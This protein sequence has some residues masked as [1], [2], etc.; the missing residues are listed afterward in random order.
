MVPYLV[1]E[2]KVIAANDRF[3]EAEQ[4]LLDHTAAINQ[5]LEFISEIARLHQ[6]QSEE[7]LVALRLAIRCFNSGAAAL[8]LIRC[9]Y[10]QQGFS[11]VRDI[12]E[13]AFLLDLFEYDSDAFK[14]WISA[15]PRDREREFKTVKVRERLD[16]RDGFQDKKRA[17]AYQLFSKYASHPTPEGFA[18]ISP[19]NQTQIGP[20]PDEER[21]GAGLV[22]L[23]R[24]LSYA[25]IIISKHIPN[26]AG[27]ILELKTRHLDKIDAWYE[28]YWQQ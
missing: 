4:A 22:E 15:A 21:L 16:E 7:E 23:S 27:P 13:T 19:E 3:I 25:S 2:S 24:Y 20:F 6:H 1:D 10:Y 9:G 28:K 14:R 8:R 17:E 5:S 11:T 18:V 12:I 26:G